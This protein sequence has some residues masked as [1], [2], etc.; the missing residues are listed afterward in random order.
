MKTL[1]GIYTAYG[2]TIMETYST[3][4]GKMIAEVYHAGNSRF[5]SAQTFPL[6]G[7]STL[8][9]QTI[10]DFCEQTGKE[11]AE[12]TSAKWAGCTHDQDTESEEAECFL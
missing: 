10:A 6:G 3:R 4:K 12:E 9:L 2:Y 11:M 8:S 7:S 5:D 1:F